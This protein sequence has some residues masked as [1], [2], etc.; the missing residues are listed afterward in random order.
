MLQLP[1]EDSVGDRRREAALMML[2]PLPVLPPLWRLRFSGHRLWR[3]PPT[4]EGE[5]TS[6]KP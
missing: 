6:L 3:K 4:E 1:S 2:L 5:G